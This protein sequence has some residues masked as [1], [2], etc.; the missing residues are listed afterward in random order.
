MFMNVKH[1]D[2][3]VLTDFFKCYVRSILEYALVWPL[4]HM[5]LI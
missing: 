2:N 5:Y 4:H 1:V 3:Y